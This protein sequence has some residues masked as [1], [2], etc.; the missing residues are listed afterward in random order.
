MVEIHD[1]LNVSN[2]QFHALAEDLQ[3][4]MERNGVSSRIQN[5]L[6]AKLAPLQRAIITK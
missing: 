3:L 1:G 2:A 5:Q 6:M 4:A